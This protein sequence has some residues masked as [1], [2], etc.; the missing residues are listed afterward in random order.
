[1]PRDFTFPPTWTPELMRR[2]QAAGVKIEPAHD[3][4]ARRFLTRDLANRVARMSFGEAAAKERLMS[5]DHQLLKA[6]ELLERSST[7]AQLLAAATPAPGG[8]QK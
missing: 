8:T 7:Q 3:S 5:E 6:V 1:V 2:L 4:G